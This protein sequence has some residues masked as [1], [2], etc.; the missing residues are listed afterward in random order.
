M[1]NVTSNR[2]LLKY[3]PHLVKAAKNTKSKK[4]KL[5]VVPKIKTSG[6]I[7][8]ERVEIILSSIQ[9]ENPYFSYTE[10]ITTK[11]SQ[12]LIEKNVL[13]EK[14]KRYDFFATYKNHHLIIEAKYQ[15]VEGS[16]K[17]KI[18]GEIRDLIHI[19]RHENYNLIVT[20]DGLKYNDQYITV[21]KT[22]ILC[23]NNG[24]IADIVKNKELKESILNWISK[25]DLISDVDN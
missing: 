5:H 2:I 24:D 3:Y 8:E 13:H 7:N 20:C 16:T 25:I 14:S 10:N 4:T 11:L 21:E 23:S 9:F 15:E 17:K 12:A 18:G 19:A 6:Q 1:S 22:N